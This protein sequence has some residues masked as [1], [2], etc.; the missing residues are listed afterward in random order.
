[1][2]DYFLDRLG[3]APEL[4]DP[5]AKNNMLRLPRAP[6]RLAAVLARIPGRMLLFHPKASASVRSMPDVQARR[7]VS[8]I[9]R[10]TDDTVVTAIPMDFQH[11]RFVSLAPHCAGPVDL[12]HII[13]RASRILTVDTSVYHLAAAL[14]VPTVALFTT[15]APEL[16]MKYYPSVAGILLDGAEATPYFG[17]HSDKEGLPP[18]A[19]RALWER[20]DVW[21]ALRELEARAAAA[22][23]S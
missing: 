15:I 9:L 11:P 10:L 6:K 13:A 5:G 16:R 7:I 20:F 3:V 1:M 21:R 19:V 23:P 22:R 17:V 2:V 14:G 12:C 18:D 4:V 8:D